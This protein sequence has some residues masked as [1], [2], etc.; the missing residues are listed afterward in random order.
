MDVLPSQNFYAL[1][2]ATEREKISAPIEQL[3]SA[4][5]EIRLRRRASFREKL[6]QVFGKYSAKRAPKSALFDVS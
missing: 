6:R 2:N 5:L 4:A 1:L 3:N